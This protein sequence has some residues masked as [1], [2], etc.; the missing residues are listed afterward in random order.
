VKAT[1]INPDNNVETKKDSWMA[2]GMDHVDMRRSRRS[3][4]RDE[5]EYMFS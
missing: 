3:N 2:V 1:Y 5:A 4:D